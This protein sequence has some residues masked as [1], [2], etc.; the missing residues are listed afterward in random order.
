MILRFLISSAFALVALSYLIVFLVSWRRGDFYLAGKIVLTAGIVWFPAVLLCWGVIHFN[1]TFF[2]TTNL[3]VSLLSV[4][5]LVGSLGALILVVW[6]NASK[7]I[8]L[9]FFYGVYDSNQIL[10]EYSH[11]ISSVTNAEL[12]AQVS[13]GLICQALKVQ[14]GFL[15]GLLYMKPWVPPCKRGY[16][17]KIFP[18]FNQKKR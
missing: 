3:I 11:G 13:L 17:F 5:F 1:E 18:P 10:R 15:F 14:H 6:K 9:L 4:L 16:P 2:L 8:S 12:L 7:L